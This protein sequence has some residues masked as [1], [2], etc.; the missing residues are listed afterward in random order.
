[1]GIEF[2]PLSLSTDET[3]LVDESPHAYVLRVAIAKAGAGWQQLRL[4]GQ[5]LLPV[6]GAD[7]AV[8]VDGNILGKPRDRDHAMAM[9]RTL[10]GQTHQVMTAICLRFM[11]RELTTVVTTA[12][13]FRELGEDELQRYWLTGEPLGK[14]GAYAIQGR[15]ALFVEHISGSYSAVVGLPLLETSQLLKKIE[16]NETL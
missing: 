12:V 15:G 8:I 14:A 5:T 1:M 16:Q 10:S 6:L 9:L 3:V 11:A 13:R 4:T 2:E 7:T